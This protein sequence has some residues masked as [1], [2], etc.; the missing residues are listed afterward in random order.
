[1][2]KNKDYIMKNTN[3]DIE[4]QMELLTNEEF[5]DFENI[6]INENSREIVGL[7]IIDFI[8]E[9]RFETSN[10]LRTILKI[11]AKDVVYISKLNKS[12]LYKYEISQRETLLELDRLLKKYGYNTDYYYHGLIPFTQIASKPENE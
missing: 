12:E 8:E 5:S 3:L 1:M 4:K 2:T 7:K 6:D 10:G 9:H 11:A